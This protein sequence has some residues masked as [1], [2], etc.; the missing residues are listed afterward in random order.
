[1]IL[2]PLYQFDSRMYK[3]DI[4]GSIAHVK[5][6]GNQ[7]YNSIKEASDKIVNGLK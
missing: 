2:I 5:M 1:M 7:G 6:L 4:K 3:Q